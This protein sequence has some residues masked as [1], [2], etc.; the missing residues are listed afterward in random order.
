MSQAAEESASANFLLEEP[1]DAQKVFEHFLKEASAEQL[2]LKNKKVVTLLMPTQEELDSTYERLIDRWIHVYETYQKA[3]GR[4]SDRKRYKASLL[5]EL[6]LLADHCLKVKEMVNEFD[7]H[8]QGA[9][10]RVSSY[11]L[12]YM[13]EL[14]TG[15]EVFK[16]KPGGCLSTSMVFALGLLSLLGFGVFSMLF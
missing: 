12:A 10:L 8:G 7:K 15:F 6:K 16:K 13:T 2:E 3:F 1:E 9:V 14:D 4:D 11:H 5:G